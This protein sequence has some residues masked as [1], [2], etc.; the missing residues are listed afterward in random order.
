MALDVFNN[1][2]EIYNDSSFWVLL[3][4]IAGGIFF[5]TRNEFLTVLTASV[6]GV[7]PLVI[8]QILTVQ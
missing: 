1:P 6:I 4:A 5:L 2:K 7:I 8:K 3:T